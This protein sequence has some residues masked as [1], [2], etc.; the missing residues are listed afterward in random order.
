MWLPAPL[1][2]LGRRVFPDPGQ[3]AVALKAVSFALVGVVNATVDFGVFSFFYFY[4][5][6]PIILANMISWFVAV[7]RSS[8]LNPIPTFPAGFGRQ[9]LACFF[10]ILPV[11]PVAG[12]FPRART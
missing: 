5:G 8:L 12:F 1:E 11:V 6:F 2:A 3:R 4:L 10:A 9:L 7:P